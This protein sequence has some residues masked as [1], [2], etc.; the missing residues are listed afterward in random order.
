MKKA[1]LL[2]CIVLLLA[3]LCA[4]GQE[5]A[6]APDMQER[7]AAIQA[8]DQTPEMLVVPPEKCALLFGIEQEDCAQQVVAI[9]ADSLLADECWLIE[10][11]DR[12]AADRIETLAKTRLEQKASELK[13]Y[14]P[15]QYEVVKQAKLLRQGTC[16]ILLVSPQAD[17][18]AGL[19][20]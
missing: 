5:N 16:V 19:F 9:C 3:G 2:F 12:A 13:S 10:A 18:L 7:F 20:A 17:K 8:L 14:L 11:V 4:C 1:G 15:E 6:A